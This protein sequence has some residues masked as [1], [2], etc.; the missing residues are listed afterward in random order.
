MG[1]TMV[2]C[3]HTGLDERVDLLRLGCLEELC[4]EAYFLRLQEASETTKALHCAHHLAG[5]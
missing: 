5:S 4:E 2:D 3:R 1:V